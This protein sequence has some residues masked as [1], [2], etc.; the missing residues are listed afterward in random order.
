MLLT[1]QPTTGYNG[2]TDTSGHV[3]FTLPQGSYRF[4]ADLNGTQFWSS[5]QND[6]TVPGCTTATVTLPSS[7]AQQTVTINYTYDALNRLTAANYSETPGRQ[8]LR[9]CVRRGWKCPAIYPDHR[10]SECDHNLHLRFCQSTGHGTVGQCFGGALRLRC[11][12]QPAL[13]WREHLCL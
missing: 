2:T 13:Q 7:I 8:C 5:T 3:T 6:C 10:H 4:R 1:A 11:G 12:W 9:L